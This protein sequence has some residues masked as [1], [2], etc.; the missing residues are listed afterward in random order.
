MI[1]KAG[2][3]YFCLHEYEIHNLYK[4]EGPNERLSSSE[5]GLLINF[6]R[7][8]NQRAL[9]ES[10]GASPAHAQTAASRL[11]PAWKTEADPCD[12]PLGIIIRDTHPALPRRSSRRPASGPDLM[13]GSGCGGCS[14][15]GRGVSRFPAVLAPRDHL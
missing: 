13:P 15:Q 9:R 11:F 1:S 8:S 12:P 10:G 7:D 2:L 4:H 14:D 6:S 3:R 5:R